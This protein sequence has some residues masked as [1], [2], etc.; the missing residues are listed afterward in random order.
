MRADKGGFMI[1]SNR[2]L[3]MIIITPRA[4]RRSNAGTTS[5][6]VGPAFG[7]RLALHRD[8]SYSLD[9]A[10]T[11]ATIPHRGEC[12]CVQEKKTGE[13]TKRKKMMSIRTTWEKHSA[14]IRHNTVRVFFHT[15]F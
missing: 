14:R 15:Q 9:R 8:N 12:P 6:D 4:R 7:R 11:D 3:R 1:I 13:E 5:P 2:R 10:E